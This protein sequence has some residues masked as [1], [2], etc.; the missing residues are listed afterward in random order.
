MSGIKPDKFDYDKYLRKTDE[1]IAR[2][3][4]FVTGKTREFLPVFQWHLGNT[5]SY[6]SRYRESMLELQLEAVAQTLEADTD[7]LPYIEPW[8]GVGVFAEAFGCP[9]EWNLDDAPWTHP[10]V[11]NIDQLKAL[12][13][14]KIEDCKM[15]QY[16]LETI[17]YFDK[18]TDGQVF[19]TVTDTQSPLD[20]ATMIIDTTFFF[21]AAADYPEELH[22]VI[23]DIT[24]LMIEFSHLQREYTSRPATPGHNSWAHPKLKGLSLSEDVLFMVGTDFYNEFAKPYNERI[25]RELGGVAIHSCGNWKHNFEAVSR[26]EGLVAV[27]FAPHVD[28]DPTPCVPEQ[29]R[30]AFRGKDFLVKAHFP[31]KYLDI[32]DRLYAPDLKLMW[33]MYWEPDPGIRQQNYD[34]AKRRFE[35][36]ST[37]AIAVEK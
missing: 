3:E 33:D 31:G 30:D 19:M 12:K 37:S 25:A 1:I 28:Y 23:S 10:I 24:D 29:A 5:F 18:A 22:R 27:D 14:P 16:V 36:L 9:F 6:D 4:P 7:W 17:K 20:T 15:L 8:H 2:T 32:L 11:Y 35:Q 13:K 26:T 34:N 21:Y